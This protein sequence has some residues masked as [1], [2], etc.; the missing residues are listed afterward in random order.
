MMDKPKNE[1]QRHREHREKKH[2][3]KPERKNKLQETETNKHC[4]KN[5]P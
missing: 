3:G 2:R 1:P 5:C 4:P